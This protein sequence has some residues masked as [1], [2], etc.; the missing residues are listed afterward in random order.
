M[1]DHNDYPAF[2]ECAICLSNPME[3]VAVLDCG[4]SYCQACIERHSQNSVTCPCCRQEFTTI[5]PNITLRQ[6]IVEWAR[7]HDSWKNEQEEWKAQISDFEKESEAQQVPA[8]SLVL[9][10][11]ELAATTA[12]HE[13]VK[14]MLEGKNGELKQQV[15]SKK[16]RIDQ[17]ESIVQEATSTVQQESN[18]KIK[19]LRSL[20]SFLLLCVN[21]PHFIAILKQMCG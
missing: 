14:T 8:R 1:N 17:L 6:T 20:V 21:T 3:E 2:F 10:Q 5:I 13:A 7:F 11:E 9:V 16:M 12:S 19:V 18:L 15:H 4:H